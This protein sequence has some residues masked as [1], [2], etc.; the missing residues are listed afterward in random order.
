MKP[1][2]IIFVFAAISPSTVVAKDYCRALALTSVRAIEDP[3]SVLFK[4]QYLDGVTA[5][6]VRKLDGGKMFCTHGGY[7]YP[8]ISLNGGK[9]A[10][11]LKLTNCSVSKASYSD[12][13]DEV[14]Y[15]VLFDPKRNAPAI[16]REFEIDAKF[17]NMGLCFECTGVATD[18]YL[19]NPISLC[20]KT[21]AL[22]LK[23]DKKARRNLRDNFDSYCN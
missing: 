22:A 13:D 4:G 19:K 17:I 2:F 12:D 5:L 23:G 14:S 16:V 3:T 10:A 6:R 1:R 9:K 11:S 21:A 20:G 18:S 7:C 8:S 15:A